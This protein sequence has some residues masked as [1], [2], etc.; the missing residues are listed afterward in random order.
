MKFLIEDVKNV[1]WKRSAGWK[2]RK[3]VKKRVRMDSPTVVLPM[4]GTPMPHQ[5]EAPIATGMEVVEISS[6]LPPALVPTLVMSFARPQSSL[7]PLAISPTAGPNLLG[8]RIQMGSS[9]PG[10]TSLNEDRVLELT[11]KMHPS[12]SVFK[13]KKYMA[14]DLLNH[15]LLPWDQAKRWSRSPNKIFSNAIC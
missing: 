14:E 6:L 4:R 11:A 15:I 13:N 1:C 5:E 12:I 2:P 10:E 3:I 8:S 9:S 7:A